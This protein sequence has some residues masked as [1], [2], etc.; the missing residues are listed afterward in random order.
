MATVYEAQHELLGTRVA[1]KVL[2]P[3]LSAN[4][5]IKERFRNEAKLMASLNHPNI[6]KVID[7][8]EQPG[9]LSIVMELLEG[10]DLSQKV[11]RSGP[12]PSNEI[13]N[14]YTQVLSASQYAHEKGIVHRD[15]KP[16]N[17]FIL[18]DG[19]VKI[20][21]F[22]IAK[23][24]GQGN[25]MT[26]TGMQF[27]TPNYMSPEQVRSEKAIDH[28]SDIY[29]LGVTLFFA[30]NEK[31]PFDSNTKSQFEI[32]N[33]IV[34]E[35]IP[36]TAIDPSW[37]KMISKACQKDKERRYQSCKEWRA[38][39]EQGPELAN[40]T[41][42]I[43]ADPPA[44]SNWPPVPPQRKKSMGLLIGIPAAILIL[45][46]CLYF[47]TDLFSKV[48]EGDYKSWTYSD[49]KVYGLLSLSSTQN[50]KYCKI[51]HQGDGITK[52][53]EYNPKGIVTQTAL[54]KYE[55]G[56]IS[57]ISFMNQSGFVFKTKTFSETDDGFEETEIKRGV[58][59]HLPAKALVHNYD[60]GL[61]EESHYKSFDNS[62]GFGPYGYA[63][64]K[65]DRYDD[66][67]NWGL[68]KEEAYY[69]KDEKP[70][71]YGNYHKIKYVRDDH[72]NVLDM[73]FWDTEG[74]SV[75]N[76]LGVHQVKYVYD[77]QDNLLDERYFGLSGEPI[78]NAYG[79]SIL[80]YEVKGGLASKQMRYVRDTEI[81]K[82]SSLERLD[83]AS[84]INY[85]YDERGNVVSTL[86]R[87]ENNKLKNSTAGYAKIIYKY[88][89]KNNPILIEYYNEQ[90][91]PTINTNGLH[92]IV[93]TYDQYGNIIQES[94]FN[95]QKLPTDKFN[96]VYS[97]KIKYDDLGR[98]IARSY[99]ASVDSRMNRWSGE[100]EIDYKYNEQGQEIE[101]IY[102][103]QSGKLKRTQFGASRMVKT[104]DPQGR[105]A[106]VSHFDG[107][108]PSS[109]YGTTVN[110]HHSVNYFY[111][112]QNRIIK[113]EYRG[114]NKNL[115][116]V[117][118]EGFGSVST[119]EYIYQGNKISKQKWY[120]K[121]STIPSSVLDCYSS[122]CMSTYGHRMYKLN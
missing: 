43:L 37:G 82:S 89:D 90:G 101:L 77:G 111:D 115:V 86:Y 6:T 91:N 96:T 7:F 1:I 116:D 15:I 32:F 14:I 27:G 73:S 75:K 67:G 16:S 78:V 5:D 53:E 19:Q 59:T 85:E 39:L 25:E 40:K 81:A 47:F 102:L 118:V 104:Y 92:K 106:S 49:N 103:D 87:D 105:V 83:G 20:L 108:V 21:D 28:R 88:D 9:Q 44:P 120:T 114:P 52:V 94:Y 61:L 18:R 100:H 54:V 33:K 63:I 56:H 66:E 55:K 95:T 71:L 10:E 79:Y 31:P 34:S 84:M 42:P 35:P 68:V 12:V 112:N 110:G 17:I 36:V 23:L 8:D 74:K 30:I 97:T 70:I 46:L 98:V 2:H 113:L 4:A 99:W 3:I 69:D 121:E 11:K 119:I 65:Y 107:S 50:R 24:F 22:G 62:L 29:S 117:A 60:G 93:S 48:Y 45:A 13:K 64:V 26:Q 57:A 122:E 58:N 76:E 80:K 51:T 72:G 38:D 109:V 41:T